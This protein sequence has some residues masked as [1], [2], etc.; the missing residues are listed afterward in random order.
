M[1]ALDVLESVFK[2]EESFPETSEPLCGHDN[3]RRHV[4][5][6]GPSKCYV[7]QK[8]VPEDSKN[9]MQK[10]I[11]KD[12]KGTLGSLNGRSLETRALTEHSVGT[13]VPYQYPTR[14]QA[15]LYG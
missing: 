10:G 8:A 11:K 13:Y 6:H 2:T 5:G 4:R 15:V 3:C 9:A 12:S 7:Y 1:S 14:S